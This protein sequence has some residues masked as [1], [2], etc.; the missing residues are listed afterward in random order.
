[1][2]ALDE[3]LHKF[4]TLT[5]ESTAAAAAIDEKSESTTYESKQWMK[6]FKFEHILLPMHD[7]IFPKF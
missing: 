7:A 4:G 5:F 3:L 2:D 1:M 6:Q